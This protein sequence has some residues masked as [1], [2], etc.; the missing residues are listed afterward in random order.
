M[1]M[2]KSLLTTILICICAHVSGQEYICLKDGS[3]SHNK[4]NTLSERSIENTDKGIHVTYKFHYITKREDTLYPSAS[5]IELEGFGTAEGFEIPA[6]PQRLDRFAIPSKSPYDILIMD[7]SYVEIPME[8]PPTRSPR[9]RGFPIGDIKPIKPYSGFYPSQTI[10]LTMSECISDKILDIQVNPVQYDYMAKKIRI[11]TCLSYLVKFDRNNRNEK[12]ADPFIENIS[13]NPVDN[14]ARAMGNTIQNVPTG[15]TTPQGYLIIT[16]PE[17]INAVDTLIKWKRTLGFDV[18]LE[19]RN[20]WTENS[21]DQVVYDAYNN[22]GIKYM[23][24]VGDFE[25]VPGMVTSHSFFVNGNY[26]TYNFYTDFYYGCIINDVYPLVRR[27]RL[28]VCTL[29]QAMAVINKIIQYEREPVTDSDFYN[30]GMNCATFIDNDHNGNDDELCVEVSEALRDYITNQVGKDVVRVYNAQDTL[31]NSVTPLRWND[32]TP[33]P[34]ELLGTN[35]FQWNGGHLQTIGNINN[36][37]LFALHEGHGNVKK[38][39]YNGFSFYDMSS[40]TNGRKMPIVFSMNCLTGKYNNESCF[41]EAFIRKQN[42]GCVGIFAPSEETHS[43]YDEA[44]TIGMFDAIWPSCGYLKSIPNQ[45]NSIQSHTPFYSLGDIFDQGLARISLLYENATDIV[46]RH[47][48][49]A[50]HL[51]GDPSMEIYTARPTPF[52]NVSVKKYNN[53]IHLTLQESAKMTFFNT[54]T[55]VV[56]T[57]E[58][59]S[60]SY[61]YAIDLRICISK[62]NKIP[63]IIDKDVLCLQNEDIT[64]SINYEADEIKVGTN[65]TTVKSPGDFV[66]SSGNT[67]LKGNTVELHDNTLISASANVEISN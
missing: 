32:G 28:P 27:G 60:V 17:Y 31:G 50:F 3:V 48:K 47:T 46:T 62:H 41:A 61:P 6:L 7:S 22:Y 44:L 55:G 2:N 53:Y 19:C 63:L 36:G 18:H 35:G 45:N 12:N 38:W 13:M 10:T 42:G 64:S 58:S 66:I 1:F 51:F 56:E 14:A 15:Q 5:F 43:G 25:D 30:T 24:I 59:T 52:N 20:N 54:S 34:S 33:L 67:V 26:K 23:L 57:F 29:D 65:V 40:L 11:Y 37:V 16:V 9:T 8:I 4:P 21:V 49:E 39:G